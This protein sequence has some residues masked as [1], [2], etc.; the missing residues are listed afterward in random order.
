MEK[1]TGFAKIKWEVVAK[2]A[3]NTI[4]KALNTKEVNNE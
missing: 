2:T 3:F 1:L 4:D